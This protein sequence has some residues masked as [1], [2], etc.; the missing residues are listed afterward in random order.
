MKQ[1]ISI[2]DSPRKGLKLVKFHGRNVITF[3]ENPGGTL[4]VMPNPLTYS[5][6]LVINKCMTY[7]A[8]MELA[9]KSTVK[10]PRGSEIK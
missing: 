6:D 7:E 5:S 8:M 9:T 2:V 10:L 3:K 1:Y 4:Y